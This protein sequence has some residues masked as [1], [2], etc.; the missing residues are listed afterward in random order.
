MARP[1]CNWYA[2]G[3]FSSL[4]DSFDSCAGFGMIAGGTLMVR[5]FITLDGSWYPRVISTRSR[6]YSGYPCEET[7]I[8]VCPI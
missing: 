7:S 2:S 4:A 6:R 8:T 1:V 5:K 3:A